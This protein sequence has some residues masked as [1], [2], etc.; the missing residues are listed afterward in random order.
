M[1]LFTACNM[2]DIFNDIV[3]FLSHILLLHFLYCF[4]E[5]TEKFMDKPVLKSLLYTSIAV[6]IY[7]TCV[8]PIFANHMKKLKSECDKDIPNK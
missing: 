6:I 7:Q 5:G 1:N 8:R 3:R 2:S 4:I